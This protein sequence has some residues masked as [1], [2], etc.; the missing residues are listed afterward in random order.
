[1]KNY[2]AV[3]FFLAYGMIAQAQFANVQITPSIFGEGVIGIDPNNVSRMAG[4]ANINYY[5]Y[6]SDTGYTWNTGTLVSSY[7]V[8]GDPCVVADNSGNFYYTHLTTSLDR[9][10]IQKSTDGGATWS[11]GT[12]TAYNPPHDADKEWMYYDRANNI[13]YV[14]WAENAYSAPNPADSSNIML[15]KSTDGGL[16]WSVPVRVSQKGQGIGTNAQKAAVTAVGPAGEVYVAWCGPQGISFQKSLNGGATWL[17]QDVHVDNLIPWWYFSVQN[18]GSWGTAF[19]SI[20]CDISGGPNNG[21]IYICWS[22]QRNG[23]NNT[24]TFIGKSTDGGSTWTVSKINNDATVS[25]QWLPAL[26]VDQSSGNVY[27][28]FYDQRNYPAST[29]AEIFLAYSTDGG[30]TYTNIPI[31]SSPLVSTTAEGDYI[32]IAA[33]NNFIRP[34]W[35]GTNDIIWTA[36]VKYSLLVGIENTEPVSYALGIYNYPNP[37][38]DESSINYFIPTDERVSLKIFNSTG[39]EVMNLV[40]QFENRGWHTINVNAARASLIPGIYYLKIDTPSGSM[41]HKAIIIK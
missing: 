15:S 5:F 10:V 38:S 34:V 16:T 21:N 28:V 25:D 12:F 4:G 27:M 2:Y 13:L 20:A 6:S 39:S 23:S 19:P 31:T 35:T 22:D 30:N 3:L 11:N 32:S 24:D 8:Y 7:S 18:Y 37:F 40:E 1:M 41:T 17:L 9:V 36:L 14:T 26:C 29:L 33:H